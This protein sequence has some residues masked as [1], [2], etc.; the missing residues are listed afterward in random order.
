MPSL[1]YASGASG[2]AYINGAPLVTG[3]PFT[4]AGY[5]RATSFA[6]VQTVFYLGAKHATA[7]NDCYRIHLSTAGQ[8]QAHSRNATG[9]GAS[10]T[11]AVMTAGMW[12]HVGAMYSGTSSRKVFLNGAVS[13]NTN[14]ITVN[15]CT[16]LALGT[17]MVGASS[18]GNYLSEGQLENWGVWSST[19]TD[20]EVAALGKGVQPIH[21][22]PQSLVYWWRNWGTLAVSTTIRDV[23]D[24]AHLTTANTSAS[25]ESPVMPGRRPW[26]QLRRRDAAAA[27]PA[28]PRIAFII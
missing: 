26:H 7:T 24:R 1:H 18:F 14:A 12:Y 21:I 11:S 20:E 8:A 2:R 5:V 25:A 22:R 19:L 13:Q 4:A 10:A 16:G 27:A 6:A 3:P 17:T 23:M 28:Q 9:T 15:T